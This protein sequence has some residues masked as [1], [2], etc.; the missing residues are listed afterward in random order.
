MFWVA[1]L[2]FGYYL[3]QILNF[4]LHIAICPLPIAKLPF[5]QKPVILPIAK[6]QFSTF[7]SSKN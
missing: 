6:M 3:L 5:C 4:K 1:G 2:L 7:T